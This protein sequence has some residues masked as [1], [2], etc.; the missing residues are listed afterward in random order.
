MNTNEGHNSHTLNFK[1]RI[2]VK[3]AQY[4]LRLDKQSMSLLLLAPSLIFLLL[5]V[6][7]AL[8]PRVV[9]ALTVI[10]LLSFSAL[11][12]VIAVKTYVWKKRVHAAYDQFKG[13]VVMHSVLPP[14]DD[15]D[16]EQSKTDEE[17]VDI[18]KI[19]LH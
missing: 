19:I 17:V 3:T 16:Q 7:V 10:L 12:F 8:M 13:G 15:F 1:Q 14:S 2:A 6:A 9:I 5:A 11:F 18:K 4:A